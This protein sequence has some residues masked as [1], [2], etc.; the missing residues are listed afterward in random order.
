MRLLTLFVVCL[1]ILM[2]CESKPKYEPYPIK[3]ND[4]PTTSQTNPYGEFN[5]TKSKLKPYRQES[6][7]NEDTDR[8]NVQ[9]NTGNNMTNTPV[10][11]YDSNG[12]WYWGSS[13]KVGNSNLSSVSMYDCK[14]NWYW[15]SSNKIGNTN[16]MNL[17]NGSINNSFGTQSTFG[18]TG[19]NN[20]QFG[21]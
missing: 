7:S 3:T 9:S 15:G 13:T 18:N 6:Y 8:F 11:M 5:T 10:S 20:N 14:G 16:T 12:N 1:G 2:A 19:N 4:E 17:N 21:Y